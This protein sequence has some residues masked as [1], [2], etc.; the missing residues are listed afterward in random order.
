M[1]FIT[2]F[3]K[4]PE[5][6]RQKVRE[7]ISLLE[8]ASSKDSVSTSVEPDN[9]IDCSKDLLGLIK[10]VP[11]KPASDQKT[12]DKWIVRKKSS[13]TANPQNEYLQSKDAQ[14]MGSEKSF[15]SEESHV[16]IVSDPKDFSSFS[17]SKEYNEKLLLSQMSKKQ[18][19]V[20]IKRHDYFETSINESNSPQVECTEFLCDVSDNLI[21][22]SLASE[23][24]ENADIT[25]R[26]K[27][28]KK[29][30]KTS[31]Q[32]LSLKKTPERNFP[33]EKQFKPPEQ[34]YHEKQIK[35]LEK[36]SSVKQ[37]KSPE[38]SSH[39]KQIKT[40]ELNS[41]GKQ[42]KTPEQSSEKQIKTPEQNSPEKQIK[43]P[44][45]NS[46]EKQIKTPEQNFLNTKSS[47]PEWSGGNGMES[48][49][50]KI[51][52]F[53]SNKFS[54]EYSDS[55]SQLPEQVYNLRSVKISTEKSTNKKES[56]YVMNNSECEAVYVAPAI[57]PKKKSNSSIF[58]GKKAA[59]VTTKEK[60]SVEELNVCTSDVN[61]ETET[62]LCIDEHIGDV[63]SLNLPNDAANSEYDE[64]S[65]KKQ[66]S[67]LIHGITMNA[68]EVSVS[69]DTNENL[70]S[71]K[72]NK[73]R[74]VGG[75][76]VLKKLDVLHS[77]QSDANI[78]IEENDDSVKVVSFSKK[79][80]P[81]Y[82][83]RSSVAKLCIRNKSSPDSVKQKIFKE[84]STSSNEQQT[85][86]IDTSESI[87]K[88]ELKKNLKEAIPDK[89]V[90]TELNS[91]S[92]LKITAETDDLFN[93][94]DNN[95]LS[96]NRYNN[97][98]ESINNSCSLNCD[99][100]K[101]FDVASTKSEVALFSKD[102]AFER[103]R[104]KIE[105]IQRGSSEET[106]NSSSFDS[107]ESVSGANIKTIEVRI[108]EPIDESHISVNTSS[109]IK[110]SKKMHSSQESCEDTIEKILKDNS[111]LLL[112]D[113]SSELIDISGEVELLSPKKSFQLTSKEKVKPL[114]RKKSA[115]AFKNNCAVTKKKSLHSIK[116]PCAKNTNLGEKTAF[117]SSIAECK[118]EE[119]SFLSP[120]SHFKR[121]VRN[122]LQPLLHIASFL[123]MPNE[124]TSNI[125]NKS[126][127]KKA[128]FSKSLKSGKKINLKKSL[129][130]NVTENSISCSESQ[131]KNTN[132][133]ILNLE[134][135]SDINLC[136]SKTVK[137]I[138]LDET[139]VINQNKNS[140]TVKK[141]TKSIKRVEKTKK[142]L[143][144]KKVEKRAESLN[145]CSKS[146]SSNSNLN[147]EVQCLVA[148]SENNQEENSINDTISE[149][150]KGNS[151]P[152]EKMEVDSGNTT[153]YIE[154]PLV[155][156]NVMNEKISGS[157]KTDSHQNSVESDD[158]M[159]YNY[160]AYCEMSKILQTLKID[161]KELFLNQK[162]ANSIKPN[163]DGIFIIKKYKL[164]N[165]NSVN[166]Y[167]HESKEE[168][169]KNLQD[170]K[171][172]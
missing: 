143:S 67:L 161:I 160:S 133:E 99:S 122:K 105:A 148:M 153:D 159:N 77:E 128:K 112:A 39:E 167:M 94:K 21:N 42:T 8:N 145:F 114:K 78:N 115:I 154:K 33:P 43:T 50:S 162:M 46:P 98:I 150:I 52:N 48:G 127:V 9:S 6:E 2:S 7:A 28:L 135:T 172:K 34:S 16:E 81:V 111:D 165:K 37:F 132:L 66:N 164:D 126:K 119:P 136:E 97:C 171:T 17:D 68:N 79:N 69:F 95:H 71:G 91:D 36:C 142:H 60:K 80:V 65:V 72:T 109:K 11:T 103:K 12:L 18:L 158:E 104:R 90:P 38:R 129:R 47:L 92:S 26:P 31:K 151:D 123:Q 124:T 32:E 23:V 49:I 13:P 86:N 22:S 44:E 35:T 157:K 130:S 20:L 24:I 53:D 3:L 168:L 56:N 75:K 155:K 163:P 166:I 170:L 139:T 29:Q 169:K 59:R 5:P 41:P 83:T 85:L 121:D 70:C 101:N 74:I 147:C 108:L 138:L 100:D 15:V 152:L 1:E 146:T 55:N 120:K 156:S 45:Q 88:Q 30:K 118:E 62:D 40:L 125:K 117:S 96:G 107:E 25:E 58:H 137:N 134:Q 113:K 87:P 76:N 110:T 89:T 14:K 19:K 54:V 63:K 140:K 93:I 61:I 64:R 57:S 144:E 84:L 27:L 4:L 106:N 82:K 51:K 116:N 73:K 141:K 149:S 10:G 131:H 102:K